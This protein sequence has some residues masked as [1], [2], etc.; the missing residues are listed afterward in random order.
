M[1][2]PTL[3]CIIGETCDAIFESLSGEYLYPSSST[4]EWKNI[5][6]DF[7]ET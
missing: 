1:G 7:Q 2:K 3:S 5:V 4:E 6:R